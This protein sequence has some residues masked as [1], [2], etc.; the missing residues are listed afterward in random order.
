MRTRTLGFAMALI[1]VLSAGKG[2]VQ[3]AN[4]P[5]RPVRIIVPFPPGG[6]V[7]L[8]ARVVA[9]KLSEG[10]G[11]QFYVENL[12]GA[13][14][15][16]GTRAAAAATADGYTLEFVAPDFVLSPLVKARAPF[17][18]AL[19][20]APISLVATSQEIVLVNPAVPAKNMKELIALLKANPG[21]YNFATPGYGTL[22]DLEGTRLFAISYGL[23]VVHVAFQGMAPGLT[24]T[25]AG[26]TSIVFCPIAL[27]AP[28]IKDGKLRPL[29]TES[30]KR[31]ERFPDVPTLTEAGIPNHESEFVSG[32]LAP[33]HTPRDVIDLLQRQIARIVSSPEVKERLA[34]AGFDAV[35]STPDE[36][37]T[38]IKAETAKWAPVVSQANVKID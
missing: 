10:L 34:T 15:D 3:A 33:A 20:F 37:A 32:L 28:H 13:G 11:N 1:A 6:A 24:A 4:Y 7:D 26:Q 27:A 23:D 38:W 21:K 25:L 30:G 5:E 31:S 29:A 17:D 19:S 9:Q 12:P 35:A 22:P 16:I 2:P 14:G 18:P 8:I 36:F